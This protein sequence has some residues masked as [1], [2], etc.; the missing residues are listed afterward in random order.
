MFENVEKGIKYNLSR[1]LDKLIIRDIE[2][3]RFIVCV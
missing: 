1:K 2:D 3:L